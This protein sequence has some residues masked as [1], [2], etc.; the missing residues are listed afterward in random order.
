MNRTEANRKLEQAC[1]LIWE[2]ESKLPPA[3]FPR[4][5]GTSARLKVSK[6]MS[7]LRYL[8]NTEDI[9]KQSPAASLG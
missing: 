1:N 9:S 3:S 7:E 6:L 4:T 5:Y 2:V 8:R